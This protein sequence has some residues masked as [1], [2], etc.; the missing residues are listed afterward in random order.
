MFLDKINCL[1]YSVG[2]HSS[3]SR[4]TV[5]C[6]VSQAARQRGQHSWQIVADASVPLP[7]LWHTLT[8]AQQEVTYLVLCIFLSVQMMLSHLM[9]QSDPETMMMSSFR[10][11]SS[12]KG[13]N[14]LQFLLGPLFQ[15]AH[16]SPNLDTHNQGSQVMFD[17]RVFYMLL[18]SPGPNNIHDGLQAT[19]RP[20]CEQFF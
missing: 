18:S 12:P 5:V 9:I 16:H 2:I 3:C 14:S 11:L 6:L 10:H 8:R 20:C 19:E 17:R 15:P 1:S 7:S 4:I 13:L